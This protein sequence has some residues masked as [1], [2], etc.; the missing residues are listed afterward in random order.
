MPKELVES[1]LF[2]HEKGSFTGAVARRE[3]KF[4]EA[5]GGTLF[6]DEIGDLPLEA[7]VKLLRAIQ[8]GEIDPV[9]GSKPIRVDIRLISAT[10]RDLGAMVQDG[11]FREDL[12][13]RLG[14]FPLELPPLRDRREDIPQLAEM[15]LNRFRANE[16]ASGHRL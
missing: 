4:K 2:G 3:G 12:Y 15:F 14:V 9:G 8:T 10:N 13:Y 5:D 1:I 16:N 11:R 6:L 7:Q